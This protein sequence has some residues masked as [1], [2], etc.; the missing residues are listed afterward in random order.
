M[1]SLTFVHFLLFVFPLFCN[2][3][4]SYAAERVTQETKGANSPALYVAPG[5]TGNINYTIDTQ[6][7]RVTSEVNKGFTRCLEASI[8]FQSKKL[9][10]LN[11]TLAMLLAKSEGVPDEDARKWANDILEKAPRFKT[12]IENNNTLIKKYNE[13]LSKD[14]TGKIY[15]TFAYVFETVDSRLQALKELSPQ[16]KYTKD[17]KFVLFS[18]ESTEIKPYTVRS[19]TFA[20]GNSILVTLT[21]GK[22]SGGLIETC[23]SITFTAFIGQNRRWA[24]AVLPKYSSNIRLVKGRASV[25]F[26]KEKELINNVDYPATGEDIL[27]KQFK[28]KINNAFAI[29]IKLTLPP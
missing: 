3:L 10:E 20:N 8:A 25:N 7:D 29:F 1:R 28:E 26:K 23:P 19:F 9:E 17:E 15:K 27:T 13:E 24:F 11:K 5:G 4:E 2:S 18:D 12:E 22:L 21:P 6:I 16:A 14:L